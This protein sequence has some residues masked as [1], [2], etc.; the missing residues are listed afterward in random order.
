MADVQ[1][2]C[3][4]ASV[5]ALLAFKGFPG[6]PQALFAFADD[7]HFTHYRSAVPSCKTAY[8]MGMTAWAVVCMGYSVA[9]T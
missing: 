6:V 3:I 7:Q 1:V 4:N 5:D 9:M 2:E 8:M